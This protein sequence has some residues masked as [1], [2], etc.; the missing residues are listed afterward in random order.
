MSQRR[1]V[2]L[3]TV[4]RDDASAPLSSVLAERIR[5]L[6]V[7]GIWV[8]GDRLPGS[9]R[10]ATDA[11]VSRNTA[12]AALETLISEGLLASRGRSGIY[13][14][15]KRPRTKRGLSKQKEAPSQDA[16]KLGP[17]SWEILPT[18]LFPMP[19]WRRLQS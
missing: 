5:Q 19:T 1:A 15:W 13:V 3:L 17:L 8:E 12:N 11:G 16:I 10:I 6:I 18:S 2:G 7:E 9:R 14:A 4:P